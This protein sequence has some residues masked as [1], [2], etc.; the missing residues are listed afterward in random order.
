MRT[1]RGRLAALSSG[2][3]RRSVDVF[4]GSAS[5]E[6]RCMS[7]VR[8]LDP[9]RIGRAIVGFNVTYAEAVRRHVASIQEH[10]GGRAETLKLYSDD[11][12]LSAGNIAG[13]VSDAL[14]GGPECIVVDIT[15]FTRET[16]LM[17]LD[18]V[19]RNRPRETEVLLVYAHAKEYS[20]GDPPREKWLSKGIRDVRSV[21]GFP[22]RMAPSRP[23]HLIVMVGFEGDRALELVRICEPSFVSLGVADVKDLGARP[24]EAA[25]VWRV[26]RLRAELRGRVRGL[27]TFSFRA[28]DAVATKR[29]LAR[30]IGRYPECNVVVVPMNT[31]IST[32]GTMLLAYEHEAV[33]I[34][35][36]PA[37]VYNTE[38][39]STPGSD[40]YLFNLDV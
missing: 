34:C 2:L 22:G 25:N 26:D 37:V 35:Y 17:V 8:S 23:I 29:A 31:K 9:E 32:V 11:P 12:V 7:V 24:H 36:A 38:R 28:Y 10:L 33:Q 18:C 40:Y 20:V 1:E 30:Q 4:F 6:T 15:T 16:L 5:F 27:D 39:Y 19:E 14:S 3:G 21:L 13:V